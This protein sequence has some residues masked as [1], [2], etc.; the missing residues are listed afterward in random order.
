MW[1]SRRIHILRQAAV[2]SAPK[3]LPSLDSPHPLGTHIELDDVGV[4]AALRRV[5]PHVLNVVI[6]SESDRAII[7]GVG[8]A[9]VEPALEIDDFGEVLRV[10][11][12]QDY[13][14]GKLGGE[15]TP[16]T[17]QTWLERRSV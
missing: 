11:V 1:A 6:Y 9:A 2:A 14:A 16:S 8:V 17:L 3:A 12:P 10:D 4:L 5:G 15:W 13:V 7:R